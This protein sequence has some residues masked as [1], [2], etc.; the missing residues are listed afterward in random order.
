MSLPFANL[1]PKTSTGAEAFVD[2]NPEFD[3]RG[4]VMAILD[5]G[6]DPG[7]FGLQVTSTGLP[8][9]IDIQDC[10]G[11]GDVDMK[12]LRNIELDNELN[13]HFVLGKSG[14]RVYLESDWLDCEST[15]QVRI[16]IKH[17]YDLFPCDLVDRLK[18]ERKLAFTKEH[19]EVE[20]KAGRAC[21]GAVKPATS[22][23]S[24]KATSPPNEEPQNQLSE[25]KKALEEYTDAGPVV[26]VV[27]FQDEEG[28]WKVVVNGNP[29]L[30]EYR[31]HQEF[32]KWDNNTQLN[33]G[34]NV[35]ERGDVICLVMDSG[36]HGTHVASIAGACFPDDPQRNGVAPGV[37]LVSLKIGDIRLGGGM[38]TT[39][40][41][42]RALTH[43]AANGVDVINMSFGESYA[44]SLW[45]FTEH[46]RV[47]SLMREL[48]E[49]HNITFVASAGN[50]G[51]ALS[52][53]SAP[54]GLLPSLISVGAFVDTDMKN[55]LYSLL[56]HN[57]E[58]QVA[59]NYTWSSRGPS[60]DGALGVSVSAPGGAIASV[61][62]WTLQGKDLMNGTSMSAPNCAGSV[63]LL[64]SALRQSR[65]K[66]SPVRIKRAL[67]TSALVLKHVEP[68]AQGHGLIQIPNAFA[69]C[70]K[71]QNQVH[72]DLPFDIKVFKLG[73]RGHFASGV[74]QR[75]DD[76]GKD[77]DVQVQAQFPLAEGWEIGLGLSPTSR[78]D[79]INLE[80]SVDL[81]CNANWVKLPTSHLYLNSQPVVFK[82]SLETLELGEG[83]HFA[84]VLG[85]DSQNRDA[86]PLFRVPV[87]V[88]V[89]Q[90]TGVKETVAKAQLS[91]NE[92]TRRF[93]K[94]P[95]GATWCQVTL[96]SPDRTTLLAMHCLQTRPHSRFK[97]DEVTFTGRLASGQVKKTVQVCGKGGGVLEI[98]I[99]KYW[100]Q[101][102]EINSPVSLNVEFFGYDA[103]SQVDLSAANSFVCAIPMFAKLRAIESID[104]QLEL[105]RQHLAFAP[106]KSSLRPLFPESRNAV[107]GAFPPDARILW[108][109]ELEYEFSLPTA[110]IKIFPPRLGM[111]VNEFLYEHFLESQFIQVFDS[112]KRL[113]M[114]SDYMGGTNKE[115]ELKTK[116]PFFAVAHLRHED[117]KVLERLE[118]L[119]LLVDAQLDKPIK[120]TCYSQPI[121][122]PVHVFKPQ[123]L[124][125]SS[126]ITIFASVDQSKTL[127][128]QGTY[129]GQCKLIKDCPVKHLVTLSI[130]QT[131]EPTKKPKDE[132][133]AKVEFSEESAWLA[134]VLEA[135]IGLLK[136]VQDQALFEREMN[137][138]LDQIA[139]LGDSKELTIKALLV[140]L[141]RAEQLLGKQLDG[142]TEDDL[143]SG[144]D[145]ALLANVQ[146]I[147]QAIRT[148]DDANEL[149][150]LAEI[151]AVLDFQ[152][153]LPNAAVPAQDAMIDALMERLEKKSAKSTATTGTANLQYVHLRLAMRASRFATALQFVDKLLGC[154]EA[155][156]PGTTKLTHKD[157]KLRK[158]H[159]YEQLQ[160]THIAREYGLCLL[161][162]YPESFVRFA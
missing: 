132:S 61:P 97:R 45:S 100:S 88:I 54:G 40:A 3:G 16:G 55:A 151:H 47:L 18:Q 92:L 102:P 82:L 46:T 60:L 147:C 152:A 21:A 48:V 11:A 153:V 76:S 103:P 20:A 71:A 67:E 59:L 30:G 117:R 144:V 138:V 85:Y 161:V 139:Q 145:N 141:T 27:S 12:T 157:L 22:A 115:M 79:Q 120:L 28:L 107:L 35:F 118:N 1:L 104:P 98:C 26:D 64:I 37:Q 95:L 51:P 80:L 119:P 69:M 109:L 7:A 89:P 136:Q 99:A 105:T 70:A 58:E 121:V 146:H 111:K 106:S 86:G 5:T 34:I 133:K 14:R 77:F 17:A 112:S 124:S 130:H 42:C 62:Q 131:A 84:E 96:E 126:L 162:D 66:H 57:T 125:Q 23:G 31:S 143:D 33:Y 74:Y 6:V 75:D 142:L 148:L 4:V 13:K 134:P 32:A 93:F 50:A 49:K 155:D 135:K 122:S 140:R 65:L 63:A 41:I 91:L 158:L 19:N 72:F 149:A 10:S 52:T 15:F 123:A 43:C 101:H 78:L 160:W 137:L 87:T 73:Q 38:E 159:L 68:F 8:K 150:A 81:E 44:S 39:N 25:L 116:G 29:P 36:S 24:C 154:E 129:S 94:V 56:P 9:L 83:A 108:E 114:C 2:S 90:V 128:Q 127:P 110:K 113:V 156:L 53:V